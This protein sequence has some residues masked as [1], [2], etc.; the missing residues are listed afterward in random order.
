MSARKFLVHVTVTTHNRPEKCLYTLQQLEGQAQISVFRDQCDKDY[1]RVE[2]YCKEMGYHYQTTDKH[3]GKWGYWQLHNM[4]YEYLDKQKYDY[5][6]QI[7]DDALFVENFITRAIALLKDEI[8]CVGILTTVS[9]IQKYTVRKKMPQEEVNGETIISAG[10]LDCCLVTTKKVMD[11]FRIK[12]NK[13]SKIKNPLKSSGVGV[14]QAA[15]YLKK[16]GR[17]ACISYYALLS[18]YF[19]FEQDTVMHTDSYIKKH[20]T[21]KK[22]FNLKDDDRRFIKEAYKQSLSL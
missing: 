22:R 7:P 21:K 4:I 18:D 2:Q 5:Y 3:L 20:H 9:Q 10:W 11:G 14:E 13:R 17:R 8:S 15:T 16:T 12:K 6:I 1:T 19:E